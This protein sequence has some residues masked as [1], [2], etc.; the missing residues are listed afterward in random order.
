MG[1]PIAW[2]STMS[3]SL[4]VNSDEAT[5]N[6]IVNKDASPNHLILRQIS[7]QVRFPLINMFF[8]QVSRT[9]SHNSTVATKM[10]D[11]IKGWINSLQ[12][13]ESFPRTS[14]VISGNEP[15]PRDTLANFQDSPSPRKTCK[16]KRSNSACNSIQASPQNTLYAECGNV[17][18]AAT[19]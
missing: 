11:R 10:E 13:D 19:T 15:R 2:S 9:H 4:V 7:T 5:K 1:R 3:R 14:S 6:S 12:V 8:C 16:R 17:A 18:I